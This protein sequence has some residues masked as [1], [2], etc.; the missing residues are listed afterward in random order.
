MSPEQTRT[1]FFSDAHLG[2]HDPE[3][4]ARKVRK[5]L[6]FLQH[7]GK[8]ARSLYIVGDLFDFWFEYR[9]AVPQTNPRILAAI[10]SLADA[11]LE[12]HYLGGNHDLWLGPYLSRQVGINI[13]GD[14]LD[15][16][17]DGKRFYIAHGD[18]ILP[19]DRGYRI[20]KR[21]LRNPISIALFR[22]LHPDIGISI[23]RRAALTSRDHPA[24]LPK[25][26]ERVAALA[27]FARSRFASGV[28]YVILG[29]V[30]C[31]QVIDE[32]GHRYVNLGDWIR[33][34]T[35]AFFDGSDLSLNYWE[36]EKEQTTS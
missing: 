13:H 24:N 14:I 17:I 8:H 35:Y 28:D 32:N 30:H 27:D 2:A 34:F 36:D 22:L 31:P 10:A 18:G 16:V 25:D 20:L 3:T 29:H 33:H 11:G 12:I 7:V 19:K 4:E 1:Y 9:H 23:A 6:S 15:T 26:P 21:L 5:I